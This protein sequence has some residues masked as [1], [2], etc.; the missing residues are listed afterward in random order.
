MG[1]AGQQSIL[2]IRVGQECMVGGELTVHGG[3]TPFPC[4]QNHKHR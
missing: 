3:P 1:G 2:G 4:E